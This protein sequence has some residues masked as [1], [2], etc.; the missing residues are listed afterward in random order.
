MLERC[1]VCHSK[2]WGEIS[3]YPTS[4]N[5]CFY[6]EIIKCNACFSGVAIPYKNQ[7]ELDAFYKNG[8][9]WDNTDSKNLNIH[10]LTQAEE[11]V[12]KVFKLSSFRKVSPR[13]LD[14]GAG[15]GHIASALSDL[16]SEIVKNYSFI[17][18]DSR[19][20]DKIQSRFPS[21][22]RVN[23]EDKN[24]SY[25]LIFLNHILEHTA[26]PIETLKQY[27]MSLDQDG[28]IY[29]E[30][31]HRDDKFKPDVFPHS[32]FFTKQGLS[33]MIKQSGLKC[34]TI[35]C[36]G[37]LESV[38]FPTHFFRKM[39]MKIIGRVNLFALKYDFINLSKQMDRALFDYKSNRSDGIWLRAICSK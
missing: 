10:T 22:Q 36:F 24:F 38:V 37:S 6:Q 25:D 4:K 8:E 19:L 20:A 12:K 14:V 26:S 1:P 33:E 27:A 16:S 30:V 29:I 39:R 5:H 9:Y 35:E 32:V 15:H 11:R 2:N 21:S 18:P 3:S 28:M 7:L 23:F 17:E 13:V 31:P 34:E